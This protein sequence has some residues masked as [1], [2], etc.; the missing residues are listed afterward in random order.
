MSLR[1]RSRLLLCLSA[2]ALF[3]VSPALASSTHHPKRSSRRALADRR[4]A[5]RHRRGARASRPGA[6]LPIAR[7]ASTSHRPKITAESAGAVS[8][9]SAGRRAG[10]PGGSRHE[11]LLFST[12][13]RPRTVR[14]PLLR[15]PVRAAPTWPLPRHFRA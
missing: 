12:A 6:R 10:E 15:A 8:A 1:T 14:A 5:R 11:L 2:F 4:G 13:S 3:A 7:A 9:S